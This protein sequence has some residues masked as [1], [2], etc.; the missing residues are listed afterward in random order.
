M[1]F[2]QQA[3]ARD[4]SAGISL[5]IQNAAT[6]LPA[7]V[8]SRERAVGR[9][10]PTQPAR[11]LDRRSSPLGARGTTVHQIAPK[12]RASRSADWSEATSHS[13]AGRANRF[14]R[15]FVAYARSYNSLNMR[16]RS[17]PTTDGWR[18]TSSSGRLRTTKTPRDRFAGQTRA[19]HSAVA[20]G[21]SRAPVGPTSRM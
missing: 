6:R 11:R 4:L 14:P 1:V 7:R 18:P 16:E 9:H 17:P 20:S 2:Q 3:V 10:G 19:R 13:S 12:R 15:C 5:E 8:C 21:T